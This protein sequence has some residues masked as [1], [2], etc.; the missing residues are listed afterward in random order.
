[1]TSFFICLAVPMPVQLQDVLDKIDKSDFLLKW[2]ETRDNGAPIT[3][4]TVYQRTV[5]GYA[6]VQ[7]WKGIY[8]TLD[9][10]Y[11]VLNLERGEVYEFKVTATNEVGEGSEDEQYFKNVKVEAGK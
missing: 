5:N 9:H 1:M 8:S 6:E 3:K 2:K 10:E 11:H 4:Y 7:P